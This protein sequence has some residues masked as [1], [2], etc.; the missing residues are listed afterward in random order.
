[1]GS[2][3]MEKCPGRARFSES[4]APEVSRIQRRLPRGQ[5]VPTEQAHSS[6]HWELEKKRE[7]RQCVRHEVAGPSLTVR[8]AQE[9]RAD[10]VDSV[11]SVLF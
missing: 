9:D 7:H 2:T 11:F 10:E 6:G 5:Q 3:R 8:P 1:M 4:S